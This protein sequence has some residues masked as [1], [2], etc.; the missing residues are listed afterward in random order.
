MLLDKIQSLYDEIR[1]NESNYKGKNFFKSKYF[2]ETK[3]I[4]NKLIYE[5]NR[6]NNCYWDYADF[7]YDKFDA[8][9][10]Q[11]PENLKGNAITEYIA[12]NLNKLHGV[13]VEKKYINST[14]NYDISVVSTYTVYH[15]TLFRGYND[16]CSLKPC[17]ALGSDSNKSQVAFKIANHPVELIYNIDQED[18]V[19]YGSYI[20]YFKETQNRVILDK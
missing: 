18:I 13:V 15:Y 14:L 12:N 11:L 9:K 17:K 8:I 7:I 10:N 1:V 19:N 6:N 4:L 2:K 3:S 5:Y 20:N 16:T